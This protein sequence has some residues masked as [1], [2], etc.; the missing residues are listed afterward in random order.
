M[1]K[2]YSF[3]LVLWLAISLKAVVI[4]DSPKAITQRL[5]TLV[6]YKEKTDLVLVRNILDGYATIYK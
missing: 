3:L 5:A 2:C 6:L 4:P 1:V